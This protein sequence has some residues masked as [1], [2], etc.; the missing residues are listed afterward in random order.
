MRALGG[1]KMEKRRGG[2][3]RKD[4]S[5]TPAPMPTVEDPRDDMRDRLAAQRLRLEGQRLRAGALAR[6]KPRRRKP[7]G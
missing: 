5:K 6:A 2:R 7:D 4:T 1:V 3:R